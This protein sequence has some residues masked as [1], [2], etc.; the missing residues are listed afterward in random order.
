[1]SSLLSSKSDKERFSAMWPGSRVRGLIMLPCCKCQRRT[2]CA[3]DLP[4]F[5]AIAVTTGFV[6]KSGIGFQVGPSVTAWSGQ[7][8]GE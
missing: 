5:V 7:P 1:M 6:R 3:G 8:V 4:C 2:T